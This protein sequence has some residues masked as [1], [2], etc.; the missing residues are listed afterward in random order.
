[1]GPDVGLVRRAEIPDGSGLPLDPFALVL[2]WR[3]K[4]KPLTYSRVEIPPKILEK[5]LL[6][7]VLEPLAAVALVDDCP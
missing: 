3:L 1:M 2:L 4:A 6:L 5:P 7:F